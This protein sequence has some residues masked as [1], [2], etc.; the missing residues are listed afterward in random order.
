MANSF[1]IRPARSSESENVSLVG[2]VLRAV[3]GYSALS[4]HLLGRLAPGFWYPAG[5]LYEEVQN[6]PVDVTC[7]LLTRLKRQTDND[8][9]R[10]LLFLQYSGELVLEEP[11]I[12][13]DMAKVTECA[14]KAGIQVVDQFAPLQVLTRGSPDLVATYYTPYSREFGHMT[15]KGNE[16]AAQ[17]LAG[18]LNE[19]A[20]SKQ[21][22]TTPPQSSALP[23]QNVLPN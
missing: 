8:K 4:D 22:V 11:A 9:I 23:N 5:A 6:E 15:S 12:V 21:S 3:L 16:H 10:L 17:L 1:I 2:K 13:P 20:P 18:A 19:Q 14:R 7:K